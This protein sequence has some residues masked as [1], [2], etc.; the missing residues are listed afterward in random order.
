[1]AP[2]SLCHSVLPFTYS[3]LYYPSLTIGRLSASTAPIVPPFI[4]E[5][6]MGPA[7]ITS[8]ELALAFSGLQDTWV[9]PRLL[10]Q[11]PISQGSERIITSVGFPKQESQ[12]LDR[13][14]NAVA[15]GK[16]VRRKA[17]PRRPR[18]RTRRQPRRPR[19]RLQQQQP[20]Q[21]LRPPHSG[22]LQSSKQRIRPSSWLRWRQLRL[23]G[24]CP[25]LSLHRRMRQQRRVA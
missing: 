5:R 3:V 2:G 24:E 21:Q 8:A 18:T 6:D 16:L 12:S 22:T 15:P 19:P 10:A 25:L 14:R 13:R 23:Q 7:S 1:M 17:F 11:A 20:P 9:V 4:N